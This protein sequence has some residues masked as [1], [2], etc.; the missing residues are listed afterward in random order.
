MTEKVCP[1]KTVLMG[2]LEAPCLISFKPEPRQ[3][4]LWKLP[5]LRRQEQKQGAPPHKGGRL[6]SAWCDARF[7]D[8]SLQLSSHRSP[9]L[10]AAPC[11][12]SLSWYHYLALGICVSGATRSSPCC[13]LGGLGTSSSLLAL[14][15]S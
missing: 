5:L 8:C 6:F 1:Q 14:W 9:A 3:S 2:R 7:R 10:C 4:A 13:L 12:T 15:N 11:H